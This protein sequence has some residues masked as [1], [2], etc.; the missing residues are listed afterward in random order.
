MSDA[1]IRELIAEIRKDRASRKQLE[2]A[3]SSLAQDLKDFRKLVFEG[4][5]SLM[6][7]IRAVADYA[8]MTD[9]AD[10]NGTGGE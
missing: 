3:V 5:R 7:Q 8:G 1:L 10:R 2:V 4:E 9:P 6:K